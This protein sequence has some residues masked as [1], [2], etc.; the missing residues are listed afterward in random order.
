MITQI[1]REHDG[2]R[3]IIEAPD[4]D[5]TLC[6]CGKIV[7]K[8]NAR[9]CEIYHQYCC[10]SCG[11][12]DYKQTGWFICLKCLLKPELGIDAIRRLLR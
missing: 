6:E 11:T 8:E 7:R 4:S 10:W 5:E 12:R 3:S 2:D 9:V 1:T